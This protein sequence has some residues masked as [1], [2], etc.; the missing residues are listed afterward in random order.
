MSII[1]LVLVCVR[2]EQRKLTGAVGRGISAIC[3]SGLT[4]VGYVW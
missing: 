1:G 4:R 2:D 3:G